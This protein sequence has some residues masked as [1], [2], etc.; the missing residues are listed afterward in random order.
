MTDE[1]AEYIFLNLRFPAYRSGKRLILFLSLCRVG[2][3]LHAVKYRLSFPVGQA[4]LQHGKGL[5]FRRN[6][7]P[8]RYRKHAFSRCR[9][10]VCGHLKIP[11][12]SLR[13]TAE[14]HGTEDTGETPEILVLQP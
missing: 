10:I 11:H 8:C 13:D 6:G 4:A 7:E 9:I 12:V 14:L 1:C 2:S 5:C 3:A